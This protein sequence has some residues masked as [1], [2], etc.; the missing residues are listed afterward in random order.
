MQ[1][2]LEKLRGPEAE[3]E[4]EAIARLRIEVFREYPYLYEGSLAYERNY[5]ARYFRC[6]ESVVF[7]VVHSGKII[8]AA[9]SLPLR[10]EDAA[11]QAPFQSANIPADQVFYFGESVLKKEYRG[12]G[13]GQK[14]MK[15]RIEAA[16]AFPSV[17][18]LAFCA[19]VRPADHPKQPPGY[20][21]LED[22]WK[23]NGFAP[24]QGLTTE[25]PWTDIGSS[26]ETQHLMQ[27]WLRPHGKIAT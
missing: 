18:W 9:T 12:Q 20:R 8:G 22:F 27:F 6:P 1:L 25:F 5:L 13:I 26:R 15:A 7:L 19:V 21:G 14:L 3:S 2:A 23:R 10:Y 24:Q 17:R 16:E 11:F 4:F